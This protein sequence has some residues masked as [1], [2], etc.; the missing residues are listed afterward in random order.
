MRGKRK[1][2]LIGLAAVLGLTALGFG[3]NSALAASDNATDQDST[4]AV[5]SESDER[6]TRPA[7]MTS[8]SASWRTNWGW[9]KKRCLLP[10]RRS[11]RR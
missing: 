3:I 2:A 7:S 11:V 5:V 1:L 8:S 9:T 4:A 10:S 6:T